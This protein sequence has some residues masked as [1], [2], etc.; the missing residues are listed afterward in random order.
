MTTSNKVSREDV[1]ALMPHKA[2]TRIDG[3]PT[4]KSIKNLE[5]ELGA[6]LIAVP[7]PWGVQKGHL[8]ILQDPAVFF[9]R[10]GQAFT[11]PALPPPS[12][13]VIPP[14]STVAQREQLKSDNNRANIAWEHYVHVRRI[15]VNQAAAAIEDVY[16]AELDDPDEGLNSV[17]IRDFIDHIRSRYCKISQDE[18]DA[19]LTKFNEGIDPSM[20]LAVY[21]RKQERCQD[22]ANDAE[23]PISQAAMVT[24]GTKHA[25]QCGGM[26]M[27]WREWKRRPANQQTWANWKTDWT[28]A[29]NE[30]R[31]IN[32]LTGGNF[33]NQA[34][35]AVE[36]KLGEQMVMSLDN[37]A[38]A[39]VQKN[40]TVESL[41]TSNKQ[42]SD[43]I[44]KLQT[45][46]TKLLAIIE[47]LSNIK[48]SSNTNPNPNGFK[49]D[50][51][52]YCWSHGYRVSVGHNS[53]TCTKR[54]DGHQENATRSN[55]MGGK[56]FNKDW[57]PKA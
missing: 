53:K 18:I 3:E 36:D 21:T 41:V 9:Q 23:V 42:L 49:L 32:R 24:T 19:N 29:F 8:G 34:N 48:S 50:P 45:E 33:D 4:H 40:S 5:K 55:T 20:P 16:Y 46:N 56:D 17:E 43:S 30:Q 25:L 7:C 35:A 6:N 10:N 15:A 26:T 57:K 11:P 54:A 38:N 2:L 27:A 51:T 44:T 47:K 37:L 52:G 14:G 13:P 12:Y 22:F 28:Q 31:D 39:A 1:L